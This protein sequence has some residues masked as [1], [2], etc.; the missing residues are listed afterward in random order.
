MMRAIE[1]SH[2]SSASFFCKLNISK[3][4]AADHTNNLILKYKNFA[5]SY[6]NQD[7]NDYKQR[8]I[9]ELRLVTLKSPTLTRSLE[10]VCTMFCK[11]IN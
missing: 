6:D 2:L 7:Y 4:T 5:I 10:N 3:V 8:P 11:S 9:S 1:R